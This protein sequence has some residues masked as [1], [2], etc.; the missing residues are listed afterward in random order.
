MMRPCSCSGRECLCKLP[1]CLL[2]RGE[3]RPLHLKH[4]SPDASALQT[5]APPAQSMNVCGS[6]HPVH[7]SSLEAMTRADDGVICRDDNF[8]GSDVDEPRLQLLPHHYHGAVSDEAK[9]WQS[10]DPTRT[11][12]QWT[13]HCV[14][15][16]FSLMA[17]QRFIMPS[18]QQLLDGL[19]LPPPLQLQVNRSGVR[20]GTLTQQNDKKHP[21]SIITGHGILP[22]W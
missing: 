11:P 8:A 17:L 6:T 14:I 16:V 19:H 5:I 10:M 1:C 22:A 18:K 13:Q 9:T 7:A 15:S 4:L 20:S 3:C 21:F 2:R 12:E